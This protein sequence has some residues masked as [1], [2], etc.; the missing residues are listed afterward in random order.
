MKWMSIAR[1]TLVA[2][3][4]SQ[5]SILNASGLLFN[6]TANGAPSSVSFSLCLNGNGPLSCQNYTA[7]ALNLSISTTTPNHTYPWAGIKINTPGYTPSNCTPISNGYCLFSVSNT[8][9]ATLVLAPSSANKINQTITY[10]STAPTNAT[11]GGATYEPTATATSGLVVSI[12]VDESSRGVCSSTAG[13]FNFDAPGTCIFNANQAGDANYNAATQVQ[14]IIPVYSQTPTSTVVYS[15]SNPSATGN[16]VT[17]SARVSSANGAPVDG[18]VDFFNITNCSGLRLSSGIATC[19]TNQLSAGTNSIVA[20]YSGDSNSGFGFSTS[21]PFSQ[22]VVAPVIVTVPADPQDVTA[23]PGNGQVVVKWYPPANT[24]G[25]AITGYTVQYGTTA[26]ATYTTPGCST[27]S[28]SDLSC[29]VSSLTNGTPY[30][31]TVVATNAMGTGYA[32][33]SSSVTPKS[34]LTASPSNLALSGIGSGGAARTITITN[35]SSSNVTINSVSIPTP[36]LPTGTSVN[37]SQINACALGV[38]LTANGGSCTITIA[39]GTNSSS[40]CTSGASPTPSAITV[41]DNNGDTATAN[42]VV[43][44]YGCQ[45]QE[46]YLF[47]IDDTTPTTRSIGGNVVALTD[48]NSTGSIQWSAN[49][50]SI[51]GIDD[52]STIASPSPNIGP[53]PASGLLN[54]NA[55]NDGACATNNVFFSYGVANNYAVGLCKATINGYTDWYLPSVCELGPFGST[56][57]GAGNYPSETTSQACTVGS[58]NIQNQLATTSIV[59]NFTAISY[60]SST[61]QSPD[62]RN[63]AWFQGLQTTN[64]FQTDLDKIF[65]IGVR[66]V[67][68]LSLG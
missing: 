33:F 23:T 63:L 31:F 8:T 2:L 43:L 1:V 17:L 38:V 32:A 16:F 45:Y 59:T 6:V 9:P 53:S 46:G 35:N 18:T 64:D 7:S 54:C 5:V 36:D 15:S 37:T 10:T 26:S 3:F 57:V 62:P 44:G 65:N 19:T 61:E 47:S 13:G 67:R 25:E 27:T 12:T 22:S 40:A 60:W 24:G 29:T 4:L 48:Q 14:Q 56:G 68:A 50:D 30:T 34:V 51:W 28:A 39:P 20:T 11:V 41:T 52:T 49:T 42:I 66:C 21:A 58:T 55:V